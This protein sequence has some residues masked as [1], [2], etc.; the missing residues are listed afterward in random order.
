MPKSK[1]KKP[2][3]PSPPKQ[4]TKSRMYHVRV[5]LSEESYRALC[6]KAAA[7]KPMLKPHRL[8]EN[9]VEKGVKD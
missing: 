9:L 1:P 3:A 5:V 4:F 7:A 2:P 8:A 6:M